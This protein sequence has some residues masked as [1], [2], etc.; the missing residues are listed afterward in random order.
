[1]Q[2]EENHQYFVV[3]HLNLNYVLLILI[4]MLFD[5][6][7]LFFDDFLEAFHLLFLYFLFF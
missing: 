3:V 6:F 5:D 4:V 2:K 1:M 7:L